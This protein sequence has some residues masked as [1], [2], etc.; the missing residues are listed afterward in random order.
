MEK[1]I[2]IKTRYQNKGFRKTDGK[3]Y[4][5]TKFLTQNGD[6]LSTFQPIDL[7]EGEEV[8]VEVEPEALPGKYKL[9]RI[10]D[11][12][13]KRAQQPGEPDRSQPTSDEPQAAADK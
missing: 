1:Q 9:I 2:K 5:L 4:T 7:K 12:D 3:P 6:W 8:L 11:A 13:P 10:I